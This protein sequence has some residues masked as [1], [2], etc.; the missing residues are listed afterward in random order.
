MMNTRHRVF[1]VFVLALA[2]VPTFG[3]GVSLDNATVAYTFDD[4]TGGKVR[5][6]APTGTLYDATETGNPQSTTGLIGGGIDFPG[7]G[8]DD[9]IDTGFSTNEGET[10][11]ISMWVNYDS[12][13]SDD[14]SEKVNALGVPGI[15]GRHYAGTRSGDHRMSAGDT[16]ISGSEAASI[17]S[18]DHVVFQWEAGNEEAKVWVNGVNTDTFT[19]NTESTGEGDLTLGGQGFYRTMNGQVDA[20]YLYEGLLSNTQIQTLYN[21]GS[22]LQPEQRGGTT[23]FTVSAVDA[24]D[25]TTLQNFSANLTGNTS[26]TTYVLNTT[27]GTITTPVLSDSSELWNINVTSSDYQTKT[28][29]DYNV[30]TN[31]EAE[32]KQSESK[33]TEA[34]TKVTNTTLTDFNIT[35]QGNTF[36]SNTTVPSPSSYNATFSKNGWYDLT[37]S[38]NA[39]LQNTFQNVF[40]SKLTVQ[41]KDQ[42]SQTLFDNFTA[43]IEHRNG[44]SETTNTTNN[45]VVFNVEKNETYNITFDGERIPLQTQE[46][47]VENAT[48]TSV[49]ETLQERT[50]NITFFD[51]DTK[52]KIEQEVSLDIISDA[53]S[54]NYTTNNGNLI[55]ELLTPTTYTARYESNGYPRRTTRLTIVDETT[56]KK[57]LYLQQE[58]TSE[59]FQI[60]I[61]GPDG[62][63]EP[64]L[65]VTS[66]RYYLQENTYIDQ[67]T[68]QTNSEGVTIQTLTFNEE[69]YQF[70][71]T[72]PEGQ[73]LKTTNPQYLTATNI[74]IQVPLTT[75]DT[76]F[77]DRYQT[78]STETT[79]TEP[80]HTA[81]TKYTNNAQ[82]GDICQRITRQ[83]SNEETTVFEECTSNKAGTITQTYTES[84]AN[85]SGYP[86]NEYNY[87]AKVYLKTEDTTYLLENTPLNTVDVVQRLTGTVG[88]IITTT[89]VLASLATALISPAILSITT[90]AVLLLTGIVGLHNIGIGTTSLLTIAGI[91][92]AY[93]VRR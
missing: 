54:K 51:S 44:Y 65:Y 19:Y 37:Q 29:K 68:T 77:I 49:F 7:V 26:G 57:D 70:V 17:G 33:F 18:W 8:S 76:E 91:V 25:N 85:Q 39:S 20:F 4:Y 12:Y 45:T 72:N 86:Y 56:E 62:I 22:G 36:S 79:W 81:T 67:E 92:I 66:Q 59:P 55:I 43:T 69:L 74:D 31:L 15:S 71:V 46:V 40:S 63:P 16:F 13:D 87:R 32:L 30:S 14:A 93:I 53:F 2:F 60:T 47:F 88:L 82:L 35:I 6:D 61:L 78:I 23:N 58:N 5:N 48:Q 28:F 73:I 83:T 80:K 64:G 50:I 41:V 21:G 84:E 34:R 42:N 9:F 10:K 52:N 1:L 11:S 75:T 89:L 3:A 27:T 90:P 38:F 24:F